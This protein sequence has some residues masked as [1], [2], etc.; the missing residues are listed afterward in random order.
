MLFTTFSDLATLSQARRLAAF[1][2]LSFAFAGAAALLGRLRIAG[3][4][5]AVTLGLAI[6]L[7]YPGHAS[8]REGPGGIEPAGGPAWPVWAAAFGAGLAFVVATAFRRR[9]G[10]APEPSR[11][12][13][14]AAVAF[15]I[16]VA[17][18]SV[19][20][21][22]V[23]DSKPIL[24][25]GFV[26]ALRTQVEPGEVV[27]GLESVSYRVVAVA[28]VYVAAA[29]PGHVWDRAAERIAD[30]RRFYA[31]G[32][33]DAERRRLLSK[34]E[35]TWLIVNKRGP[36]PPESFLS[37]L[38]RVYDGKLYAMYRLPSSRSP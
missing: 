23:R 29:D 24:A 2:P 14:F 22:Q 20:D 28:P 17:A 37:S 16:P 8:F 13:A 12:T 4:T 19:P 3:V 25:P 15:V 1:L 38:E 5:A 21:I 27:F 26:R 30:V 10:E 31:T 34:Y 9:Q 32:T 7:L 33:S 18:L 35:A 6:Q 36:V 11:W